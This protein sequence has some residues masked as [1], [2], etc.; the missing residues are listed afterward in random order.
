[1]NR[2]ENLGKKVAAFIFCVNAFYGKPSFKTLYLWIAQRY[3]FVDIDELI[4][5]LE[6]NGFNE[7][8]IKEAETCVMAWDFLASLIHQ[9]YFSIVDCLPEIR[10]ELFGSDKENFLFII[11]LETDGSFFLT[12]GDRTGSGYES[13]FIK[14]HENF[15]SSLRS[16][17]GTYSFVLEEGEDVLLSLIQKLIEL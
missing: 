10:V 9:D 17:S 16:V 3:L 14:T 1:M 5:T 6:T 11:S 2:I 7:K 15:F 12:V 4:K 8:K 13:H